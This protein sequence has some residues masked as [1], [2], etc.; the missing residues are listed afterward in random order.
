MKWMVLTSALAIAMIVGVLLMFGSETGFQE[1]PE[2]VRVA[3]IMAGLCNDH[4]WN[5]SHCEAIQKAQAQALLNLEVTYYENVPLD[6]T[7]QDTMEEAVRKGAKIVIATSFGYGAAEMAVARNHPEVTFF[8]ATG[9]KSMTN[10]SS[11]FGRMYQLRYLSGIVAGLKTKTNEIGYVAGLNISEV[12]RGINAFALGVQK[13]NP[14]AK[15][16][17]SWTG[18]CNDENRA[19]D[20]TRSLLDNHN[21]DVLTTH[22]DALSPYNIADERNVWIIGYNRDNSKRFPDRF[23]TAPV[24]HW[25]NFYVPK[26][27]EVLQ[28]KFEGRS[29]WLGLESGMMDLAEMTRNVEASIRQIVEEEKIHLTQGKFDVFYGP[30]EDNQGEIRVGE[31]ESMTDDEMLNRFDWFVK[32]VV[33]GTNP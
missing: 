32:G 13:V 23:L 22:L 10:L 4:S 14:E 30:I 12:N 27:R 5:E 8:H 33:D 17:V 11:F 16:F 20:S 24:W 2:K 25:E 21:I 3:V 28:D 1:K 7:A 19:A 9:L 31:G 26:I 29:Y 6:S 15:V 18:S